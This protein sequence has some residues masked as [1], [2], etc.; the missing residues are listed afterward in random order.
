[1]DITIANKKVPIITKDL[2]D[3]VKNNNLTAQ[4]EETMNILLSQLKDKA[5]QVEGINL[6]EEEIWRDIPGYEGY[7]QVSNFGNVKS[8]ERWT[9]GRHFPERSFKPT[10]K[11]KHLNLVLRKPNEKPKSIHL[12]RV[13]LMAF[14]RMPKTEEQARHL[15]GNPLNCHIDNLE[16]GTYQENVQD[17]FNMAGAKQARLI[18][19]QVKEIKRKLANGYPKGMIRE[20]E[21]EYKVGRGTIWN[22]ATG[23]TWKWVKIDTDEDTND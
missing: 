5:F 9:N 8:L 16:W 22:I 15:D 12:A 21:K 14:D 4:Q 23:R 2:S 10:Y 6:P 7:Y 11:S 19:D 3:I 17:T 13:V 1:M 18:V 20:L